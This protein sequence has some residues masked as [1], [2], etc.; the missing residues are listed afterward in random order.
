MTPLHISTEVQNALI[1]LL[2]ELNWNEGLALMGHSDDISTK[3]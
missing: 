3:L 1:G 2:R